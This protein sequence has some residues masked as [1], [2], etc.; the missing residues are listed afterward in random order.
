[1]F[2]F[3]FCLIDFIDEENFPT[4]H[5][6]CFNDR[7]FQKKIRTIELGVL[8]YCLD[9]LVHRQVFETLVEFIPNRRYDQKLTLV[10]VVIQNL[11]CRNAFMA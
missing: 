11:I 2:D 3:R 10:V 9:T 1:M 6:Q 8:C 7:A 4:F 5:R